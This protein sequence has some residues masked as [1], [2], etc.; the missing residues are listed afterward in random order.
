MYWSRA[1][2]A[3]CLRADAL[4]VI[5]FSQ[6]HYFMLNCILSIALNVTD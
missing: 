2:K 3:L 1:N 6:D 4:L 5:A